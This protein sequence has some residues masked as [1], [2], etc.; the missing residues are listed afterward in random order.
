[1]FIVYA[2]TTTEEV[3]ITTTEHEKEMLREYFA[4]GTGRKKAEYDRSESRDKNG[5]SSHAVVVTPVAR[6]EIG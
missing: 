3:I 4:K 1:M 5:Y 2:S 6:F